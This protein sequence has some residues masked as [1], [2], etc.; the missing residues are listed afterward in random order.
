MQLI[1]LVKEK[2]ILVKKLQNNVKTDSKAVCNSG[3]GDGEESISESDSIKATCTRTFEKA[4]PPATSV[5]AGTLQVFP[6]SL[7]YLI[8]FSYTVQ[9]ECTVT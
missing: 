6:F 2:E 9:E 8:S 4:V 7:L 5:Q 3:D 1:T